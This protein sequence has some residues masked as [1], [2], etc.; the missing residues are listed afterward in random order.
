MPMVR[1]SQ[2]A[3]EMLSSLAQEEGLTMTVA[4]ERAL[5]FY[6]ED[7]M[8]N[9]VDQMFSDTDFAESFRTEIAEFEGTLT[10]GL[11]LQTPSKPAKGRVSHVGASS[12]RRRVAKGLG[13]K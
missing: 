12:V 3:H 8:W 6:N 4:L 5:R 2:A 13:G 1:L 10:D 9:K 7:R 11:D